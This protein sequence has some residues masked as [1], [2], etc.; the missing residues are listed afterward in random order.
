[1]E[2]AKVDYNYVFKLE[3]DYEEGDKKTTNVKYTY[4]D[5]KEQDQEENYTKTVHSVNQTTTPK[6]V[7][8]KADTIFGIWK[9]RINREQKLNQKIL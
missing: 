2:E 8:S 1:M 3:Y 7:V 5:Y 4:T 6:I 9:M